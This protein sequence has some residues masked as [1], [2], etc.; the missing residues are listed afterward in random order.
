M[1]KTVGKFEVSFI[2]NF[3]L[4]IVALLND[5]KSH[6]NLFIVLNDAIALTKCSFQFQKNVTSMKLH[7]IFAP[8]Q[9]L[10]VKQNMFTM[11]MS[12]FSPL[13]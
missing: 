6:V 13:A 5:F 12:C 11:S 8:F 2:V 1:L 9:F 3:N 4:F 10:N 7:K